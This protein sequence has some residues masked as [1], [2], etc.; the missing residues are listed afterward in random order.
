MAISFTCSAGGLPHHGHASHSLHVPLPERPGTKRFEA[1][2]ETAELPRR[3]VLVSGSAGLI[4]TQ[5]CAFLFAAG[6]DGPSLRKETV[7]PKHLA[8]CSGALDK[9]ERCSKSLRALM[10]SFTLPV[11]ASV[12]SGG[13]AQGRRYFVTAEPDLR[14]TLRRPWRRA[15]T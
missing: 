3:R 12:T 6:H 7:L 10:P 4:G 8:K 15:A 5:L 14:A 2:E 1:R 11:Q 13:P 9:R